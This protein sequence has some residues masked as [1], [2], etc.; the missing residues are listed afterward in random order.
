MIGFGHDH[1]YGQIVCVQIFSIRPGEILFCW[2]TVVDQCQC[3]QWVQR[4][5]HPIPKGTVVS[6]AFGKEFGLVFRDDGDLGPTRQK[7]T[8]DPAK[9]ESNLN[10]FVAKWQTAIAELPRTGQEIDNLL[11]HIRN[12]C[13]SGI[14]P[15]QG[16]EGNENLHRY[17]NRCLLVGSTTVGP[18]LAIAVLTIRFYTL[19]STKVEKHSNN[20]RIVPVEPIE[21]QQ[22]KSNSS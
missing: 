2:L 20:S 5:V 8:P 11:T 1:V 15:G 17:I 7:A 13:L 4:V 14:Q 9:L 19:N 22:R 3:G 6:S 18:E 12:G 21:N 16:T 10:K